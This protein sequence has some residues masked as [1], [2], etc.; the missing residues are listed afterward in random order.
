[1]QQSYLGINNF[2]DARIDVLDHAAYSTYAYRPYG[3]Y[4]HKGYVHSTLAAS[5]CLPSAPFVSVNPLHCVSLLALDMPSAWSRSMPH[6]LKLHVD[7]AY[8]CEFGDLLYS[9][10]GYMGGIAR[11]GR[12]G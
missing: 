11:S 5:L 7:C 9:C 2:Q 1:M 12:C 4:M 3:C 8:S 6:M 10:W